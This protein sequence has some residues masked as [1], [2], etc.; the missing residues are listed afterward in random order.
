MAAH[1][2]LEESSE[3]YQSQ[4]VNFA[5]CKG[6]ENPAPALTARILATPSN[7]GGAIPPHQSK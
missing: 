3:K 4:Q 6:R 2:V 5:K 1:I 7:E